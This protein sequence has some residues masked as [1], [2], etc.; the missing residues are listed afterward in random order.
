M[1]PFT[2]SCTSFRGSWGSRR[3]IGN[4]EGWGW[5]TCMGRVRD[6]GELVE[7]CDR[8]NQSELVRRVNRRPDPSHCR[9]FPHHPALREH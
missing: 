1:I 7:L 9:G 3:D 6:L 4:P 8:S 2:T 5:E